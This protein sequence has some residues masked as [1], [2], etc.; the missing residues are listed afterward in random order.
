MI[1]NQKALLSI[2]ETKAIEQSLRLAVVGG[3]VR[4]RILESEEALT[5]IDICV[6]GDALNFAEA[7]FTEIKKH[8]LEG[9]MKRFPNFR[10]AHLQID[11]TEIDLVSARTEVYER[12]GS[13]PTVTNSTIELDL[14]RRDF[15]VNAIALLLSDYLTGKNNYVDPVNGQHDIEQR[16]ISVIHAKS[17]IDDPT[18]LFRAVRYEVRL[19]FTLD[20]KTEELFREAIKANALET[21][22]TKRIFTELEKIFKEPAWEQCLLRL[23][24]LGVVCAKYPSLDFA[25]A[26]VAVKNA[27]EKYYSFLQYVFSGLAFQ[28]QEQLL[29]D[30]SL[31]RAI[32]DNLKNKK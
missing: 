5:D 24:E 4:D 18:R 16:S 12:P 27:D 8:G 17:F 11:A 3:A 20:K 14:P 13:L 31:P 2:V 32:K 30:L 29:K 10:S 25:K 19:G 6:E 22:S 23:K 1:T 15:S 7:C 26:S 21:I 28:Q 9:E